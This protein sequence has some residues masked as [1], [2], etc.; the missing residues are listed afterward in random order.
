MRVD[1]KMTRE[2]NKRMYRGHSDKIKPEAEYDI[3]E[4]MDI[5]AFW[6]I[7]SRRMY[8]DV[9][10]Q[11]AELANVLQVETT[12]KGK[13]LRYKIKG[14]NIIRFYEVYGHGINLLK[15]K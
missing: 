12:G 10:K 1:K 11:D 7:N 4:L 14:K 13:G 5:D 2:Y 3:S 8:I 6:W 15:N 9:V